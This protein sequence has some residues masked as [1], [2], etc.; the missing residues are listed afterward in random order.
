MYLQVVW[1]KERHT[2][3]GLAS[4][5]QGYSKETNLMDRKR[6][7]QDSIGASARY[8]VHGD[9]YELSTSDSEKRPLPHIRFFQMRYAMQ[10]IFTG[11]KAAGALQAIFGGDPPDDHI[12]GSVRNEAFLP[13][14][15]DDM[16]KEALELGIL[17][18]RTEAIW[19][20]SLLEMAYHEAIWKV[21]FPKRL[22]R[23]LGE[24]DSDLEA[25]G[26]ECVDTSGE[27]CED[28]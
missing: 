10:Q 21:Q 24:S 18:E 26:E 12:P 20:K 4:G 8:V 28:D 1:F 11:I 5:G 3:I 7:I 2:E 16:L 9:I 14:D 19:R 25:S 23:E 15:W 13:T 17:N 6:T 22:Q 27:E